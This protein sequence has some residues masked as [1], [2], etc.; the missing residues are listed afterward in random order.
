[1]TNDLLNALLHISMNKPIANGSKAE[2][3]ISRVVEQY[4]EQKHNKV[5]QILRSEENKQNDMHTNKKN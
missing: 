2:Q 4:W 5:P 3:L 1:M